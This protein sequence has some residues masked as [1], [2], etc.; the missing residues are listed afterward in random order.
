MFKEIF[1]SSFLDF[2]FFKSILKPFNCSIKGKFSLKLFN[3]WSC[4]KKNSSSEP[5]KSS[6]DLSQFEVIWSDQN[7]SNAITKLSNF[8]HFLA[9]SSNSLNSLEKTS[10]LH[11]RWPLNVRNLIYLNFPVYLHRVERKTSFIELVTNQI[12]LN[13]QRHSVGFSQL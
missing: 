3:L 12:S 13:G 7:H 4:N 9:E 10:R 6:N 11:I 1:I 2:L 5:Y 8:L